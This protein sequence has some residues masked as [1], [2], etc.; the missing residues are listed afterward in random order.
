MLERLFK[1]AEAARILGISKEQLL[2]FER[3]GKI[4]DS[5]RNENGFRV[6]TYQEI[7]EIRDCAKLRPK[8]SRSPLIVAVFNMK[9][10][11]GKS[12]ISS[13]LAWRMAEKGYRTLAVDADPQGHMT[14]SLGMEPADFEKTL[15][16][17]L[18]PNGKREIASIEE[19]KFTITPTLHLIPAKLSMCSLNLLLFQQPE[20][21]YRFRRAK[22][23]IEKTNH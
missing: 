10:G 14:T 15:L 16:Q 18:V 11:V 23:Q 5:S 21:E 8:L 1:P 22:E 4:P 3:E 17:I 12:T 2:S 13:N 20:R 7:E 19:T 9:G 6:Y